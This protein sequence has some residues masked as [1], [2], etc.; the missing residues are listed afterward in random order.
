[1]DI[2]HGKRVGVYN[3]ETRVSNQT[4]PTSGLNELRHGD[5][6]R[7]EEKCRVA[8]VEERE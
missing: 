4:R 7:V 1:L 3:F 2:Y 5:V 8:F 6:I